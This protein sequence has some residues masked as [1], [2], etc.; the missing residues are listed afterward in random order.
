MLCTIIAHLLNEWFFKL[1]SSH[2]CKYQF[3]KYI[4]KC[5]IHYR[6][7]T[8]WRPVYVKLW[9]ATTYQIALYS[10][11]L[12]IWQPIQIG[13]SKYG[14]APCKTCNTVLWTNNT[15]LWSTVE[16]RDIL[17]KTVWSINGSLNHWYSKTFERKHCIHHCSCK[18]PWP[19]RR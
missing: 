9:Y 15:N 7:D 6:Y 16:I 11:Q 13:L 12:A 4:V 1:R 3:S 8:Q 17:N 2:Y 14:D 19:F 5:N 18:W 10:S